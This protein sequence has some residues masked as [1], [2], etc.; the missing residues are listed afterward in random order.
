MTRGRKAGSLFAAAAAV[1]VVGLSA[2]PATAATSLTVKV[3]G[4]GS[5]TATAAKTV[6]SDH[7]VGV[8][9]TSHNSTHASVATGKIANGAYSGAAPVVI[10]PIAT[11]TFGHCSGL[12]GAVKITASSLP[13]S[14]SI[15]SKT[16][17]T[18]KTDG[19]IVGI[20]VAISM[21][22]CSFT[23][24]GSSPF[25]YSNSKHELFMT[26]TGKLPVKPLDKAQLTVSN[27]VGCASIIN[28]GDHP[29]YVGAYAISRKVVF[30]SR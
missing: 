19:M 26:K 29:T 27:V 24:T 3:S 23:V 7:G 22:G 9:C 14:L 21:A 2:V 17:S 15:D 11:L 13:Y 10:T 16:T 1:A 30:K 20:N 8:T 25:Y 5:F 28:N 18:G 6:L 4:G 12:L